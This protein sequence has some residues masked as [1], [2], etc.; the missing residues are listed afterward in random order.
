[1]LVTAGDNSGSM[2]RKRL[3]GRFARLQRSAIGIAV[4]LACTQVASAQSLASSRVGVTH[5]MPDTSALR[6]PL[7]QETLPDSGGHRCGT[8]CA[9]LI[10]AGVGGLVGAGLLARDLSHNNGDGFIIPPIVVVYPLGGIAIGTALGL[11]VS[12]LR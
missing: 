8:V 6:P 9:A 3:R 12:A 10:G 1:M 2:P 11:L 5:Q 4:Q 7:M